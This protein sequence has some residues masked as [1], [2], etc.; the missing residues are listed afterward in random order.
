MVKCLTLNEYYEIQTNEL[1]AIRSIYMDDFV[2]FTKKKSSWDKQPQIIFEISL[3]STD[4]NPVQSS[5]TLHIALTPMYPHTAPEITFVNVENVMDTQLKT[6]EN[7]FKSIHKNAGGQ[8]FIFEITSVVQEKLDEF[9]NMANSHSLED[10]RL[11]RIKEAKEQ[12]EREEMER[13]KKVEQEKISEQKIIDE[14]VQKELEKRKDDDDVFFNPGSQMNLLPP[15]D[16]VTSGEA[17]VFSKTIKAKLPNNSMYKFKAVVNPTPIKLDSDLFYFSKQYLVKPYI[18]P[19]SPLADAL[20]S[21]EMMENF[22]Y[23]LTEIELDNSYFNTSNGKK[24]ISNLEKTLESL[25]KVKQDNVN[26][27]YAYT[28]ERMGRNNA[29]FVWKIKLLTEYSASYPM[30]DVLQSVGYVNLATARIWMIRLLEG[31]EALHKVGIFHKC[32]GSESISLAKDSDFGTT[33]PKLMYPSFGYDILHMLSRYPN[34][35]GIKVEVPECAWPPPEFSKPNNNRPNLMTDIWQLGVL[36]VQMI[37]GPDT[38]TNFSSVQEFLTST[39]MDESLYDFLSKMLDDDPK[40]RLGTLELLPMK[41]LRTN[42][43]LNINKFMVFQEE[44]TRYA[45]DFEEIAVLGKGAFGQV[46]KARNTLDSRYYAIKKIRHTEE[47]LS[48]ILSEVMLLASLNHQYVVRYYAA[49]L[50][51]DAISNTTMVSSDEETD[52]DKTDQSGTE[53]ESE[54]ESES[55]NQSHIFRSQNID[56]IENSNWDFISNS[57]YPDIVFANSS[58]EQLTTDITTSDE[59]EIEASFFR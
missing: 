13:Q 29:T 43:D 14:I 50:E 7:D 30:S 1:E 22:Y 9:Q 33:V 10:D 53:S 4:N 12:L 36:F 8:E 6:L 41:F 37:S 47:K 51:E 56:D 17:V 59:D 16:W 15:S 40:R 3:R 42:I 34:K 26:H 39:N 20:M 25:L 35:H 45:S 27:L 11:M 24:E 48:T 55:F 32:I 19:D 28:V 18:S 52:S 5:L 46:V 58:T 2:D 44:Q 21:S 57:G 23:L 54:S 31:L 38:R 49:W